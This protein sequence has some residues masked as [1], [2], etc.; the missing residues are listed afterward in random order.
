MRAGIPQALI[1][2]HPRCRLGPSVCDMAY[3]SASTW[4]LSA[5]FHVLLIPKSYSARRSSGLQCLRA[6]H[7]SVGQHLIMHKG[8]TAGRGRWLFPLVET[9]RNV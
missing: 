7:H 4:L 1:F 9:T 6:M 8:L 5:H 3:H 2:D